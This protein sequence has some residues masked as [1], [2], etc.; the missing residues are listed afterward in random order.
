L[1]EKNIAYY[2]AAKSIQALRDGAQG[3]II[4]QHPKIVQLLLAFIYETTSIKIE[5]PL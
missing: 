3:Q 1:D 4:W 2:S 5:I